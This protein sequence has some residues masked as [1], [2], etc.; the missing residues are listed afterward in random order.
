MWEPELKSDDDLSSKNVPEWAQA[1]F[2]EAF[3]GSQEAVSEHSE[4]A[5]GNFSDTEPKMNE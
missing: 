1:G 4:E 3:G 5:W 2:G